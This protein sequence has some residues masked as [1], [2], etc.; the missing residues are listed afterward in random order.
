M[1]WYI[2]AVTSRTEGAFCEALKAFGYGESFFPVDKIINK[3]WLKFQRELAAMRKRPVGFR[4]PARYR[5]KPPPKYIK[6]PIICGYVFVDIGDE[7]PLRLVDVCRYITETSDRLSARLVAPGGVPYQI[8]DKTMAQMRV[9]PDRLAQEVREAEERERAEA[10]ARKPAV[11]ALAT[12]LRGHLAG[13]VM[14]VAEIRDGA[15][16]LSE[17]VLRL[18]AEI[19]DVERVAS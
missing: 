7:D 15:V 5:R 11:G 14:E 3:H 10:E 6:T 19:E 18:R 2:A 4:M 1:T 12:V 17:G 13:R 8:R 9:L 16:W